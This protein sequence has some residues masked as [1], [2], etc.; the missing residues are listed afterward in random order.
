MANIKVVLNSEAVQEL[1]KSSEIAGICESEA[2]RM[3]KA[4][5][6]KYIPDIHVGKTRVNAAATVKEDPHG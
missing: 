3:T 2:E 6:L 5:G 4:S 1:L